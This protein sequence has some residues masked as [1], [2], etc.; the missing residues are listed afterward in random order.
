MFQMDLKID[1]VKLDNG[2]YDFDLGAHFGEKNRYPKDTRTFRRGYV[3]VGAR[4]DFTPVFIHIIEPDTIDAVFK[5]MCRRR[6]KNLPP[7]AE[8][9]DHAMRYCLRKTREILG[10]V[11]RK[12]LDEL[13]PENVE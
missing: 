2:A 3:T 11:Q 12:R 5:Q 7:T 8:Q 13:K 10:S 4:N 6:L 9:A 1:Y